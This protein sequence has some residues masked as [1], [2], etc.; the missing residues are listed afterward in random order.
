MGTLRFWQ[1]RTIRTPRRKGTVLEKHYLKI[2]DD[3][4][5]LRQ[6]DDG[7]LIALWSRKLNDNEI[8]QIIDDEYMTFMLKR[9][10]VQRWPR[11]S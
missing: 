6:S 3:K 10:E 7:S 5:E 2:C 11:P 4:T 1:V 8:Q 9:F